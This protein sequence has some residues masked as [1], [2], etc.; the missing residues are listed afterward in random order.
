MT[1]WPRPIRLLAL[2]GL[3][4]AYAAL[5]S[6]ARLVPWH[7]AVVTPACVVLA[8]AWLEREPARARLW[9]FAAFAFLLLVSNVV[10][11]WRVGTA[12]RNHVFLGV[13]PLSDGEY[14][15]DASRVM[16]GA[17]MG[18]RGSKRPL[19][20]APYGVLMRVFEGDARAT[21]IAVAGAWAL[22][23]SVVVSEIRRTRGLRAAFVAGAILLMF[24]RRYCGFFQSESVGAPLGAMAFVCLWRAAELTGRRDSAN[25]ARASRAFTAWTASGLLLVT[26]ALS[27]RPGP[28]LVLPAIL[29]WSVVSAP[30]GEGRRVLGAG[31]L[32]IVAG[33]A[34]AKGVALTTAS[35]GAATDL[36]AILYG[37]LTRADHYALSLENPWVLDLAPDARA[38]AEWRLLWEAIARA[39]LRALGA[40]P[41]CLASYFTLPQGLFGFVWAN[42][43]DRVLEDGARVRAMIAEG[44]ALAPLALW[45]RE[46][47][48]YSLVNALVM[49]AEALAFVGAF[50]LGALRLVRGLRSDPHARLLRWGLAGLALSM[51]VLPPWIT[52]GAQI[53]ATVFA[54]FVATPLVA[55]G[56]RSPRAAA[57]P[58][59]LARATRGVR[60]SVGGIGAL[61]VAIFLVTMW[62]ARTRAPACAPS[63][64][65]RA[66]IDWR[67]RVPLRVEGSARA[68]LDANLE[69]LAARNRAFVED[70]RAARARGEDLVV[71]YDHCAERQVY[72]LAEPAALDVL[73]RSPDV[74]L[75]TAPVRPGPGP[76]ARLVSA[77][78]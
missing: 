28:V 49:A 53:H 9:L 72:L 18:P 67:S 10:L 61:L 44:G 33:L 31:A 63:G 29:A 76:L 45:A 1:G 6:G 60:L 19:G 2:A 51:C 26:C 38:S 32:S 34:V 4:A 36:P 27:A 65:A 7:D 15:G 48:A 25:D 56:E 42:P 74:P 16:H 40:L 68:R 23:V 66:T 24:A 17:L 58:D 11:L 69:R 30:A 37:G 21:V 70:I 35:V 46:L 55:W 39:P 57:D 47:G 77:E 64:A 62:P 5:V 78:P 13:F 43:D 71:A 20:V 3:A 59:P 75:R 12:G 73:E 41:R 50:T 22:S 54:F 8:L 52:E 14:Y